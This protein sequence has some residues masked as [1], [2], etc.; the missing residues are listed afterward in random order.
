MNVFIDVFFLQCLDDV[1]TLP[2]ALALSV[3]AVLSGFHHK[4]DK[5]PVHRK[6]CCYAVCD[7]WK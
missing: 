6:L 2:C 7:F 3:R 5:G 4:Q 1:Y